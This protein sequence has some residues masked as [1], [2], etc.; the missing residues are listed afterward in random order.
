MDMHIFVELLSCEKVRDQTLCLVREVEGGVVI[1]VS[2]DFYFK[3][4]I[5]LYKCIHIYS[6]ISIQ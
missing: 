1:H 5:H 2:T 4:S 3:N 6:Y